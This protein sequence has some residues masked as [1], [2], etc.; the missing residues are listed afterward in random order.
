M[1]MSPSN[2]TL[3][4]VFLVLASALGACSSLVTVDRTKVKDPLFEVPKPDAGSD[5]DAG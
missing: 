5:E 2:K 1:L 4:V 3:L